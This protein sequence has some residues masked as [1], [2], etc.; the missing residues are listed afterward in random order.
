MARYIYPT[1]STD[2]HTLSYAYQRRQVWAT[3][4]RTN[5]A[6]ANR[7]R[8]SGFP[9]PAAG[10]EKVALASYDNFLEWNRLVIKREGR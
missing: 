1:P 2:F 3:L 8:A 4:T 6:V 5:I 7:L 9:E 10:L